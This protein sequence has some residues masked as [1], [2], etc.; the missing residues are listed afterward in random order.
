MRYVS[1]IQLLS[2]LLTLSLLLSACGS[3][4]KMV[5]A[6]YKYDHAQNFERMQHYNF[7][8]LPK[9]LQNDGNLQFIRN[10]GAV[11]AIEN[12]MAAKQIRKERYA[13]PDFWVNFYFTGEQGI[14]VG[15]LNELYQYNLGLSWDDKYGTGKGIANTDYTFSRR[16]F[17][18][19]LVSNKNNQL[20]WRGSA[21]TSISTDDSYEQIKR[22]LTSAS[23]VILDSFPPRNIFRSLKSSDLPD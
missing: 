1:Q 9:Q 17:I 7:K 2:T 20:I 5:G 4:S 12:A 8:P 13:Q 21:P 16:T 11:L 15:Q 23:K 6:R 14:T 18:I 3:V 19:D 10:S 22:A